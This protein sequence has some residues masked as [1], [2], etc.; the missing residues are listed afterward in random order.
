MYEKLNE[1]SRGILEEKYGIC[2]TQTKYINSMRFTESI[3]W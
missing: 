2:G 1:V 3:G